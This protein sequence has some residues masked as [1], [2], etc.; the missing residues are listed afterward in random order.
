MIAFDSN[1]LFYAGDERFPEKMACVAAIL[2]EAMNAGVGILPLQALGEFAY[3]SVRKGLLDRPR[4]AALVRDWAAAFPVVAADEAA[5]DT[6]LDWWA[7][8]R[9]S[10]WDALLVAT[11]SRAGASALVSEDLQDGAIHAG[12][13]IINPFAKDAPARL[14]AH[15]LG[16]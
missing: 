13:E 8:E 16:A 5:L 4:A 1:A 6:A 2:Q 3:A 12:V 15:G 7:D 14:A 10:W 11:A 9:L